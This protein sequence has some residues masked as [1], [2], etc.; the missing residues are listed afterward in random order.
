M[1]DLLQTLILAPETYD[2]TYDAVREPLVVPWGEVWAVARAVLST[3]FIIGGL[4]FVLAGALG[5]LRLP[6]FY[7]RLH[8]A[9]MTDTLG[10]EFVLVGLCIQAGFSQVTLKLALVGFLLLIT[11]PT[12][13]HAIA[14]AAWSANL[15]PL[16]G[17]WRA[18]TLEEI[19]AEGET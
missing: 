11:S 13:T 19:E 16:L 1:I 2:A 4:I 9:G 18:P 7:T 17:R 3:A 5:V 15:D 10:A 12:A 6:D 14:S 8:A